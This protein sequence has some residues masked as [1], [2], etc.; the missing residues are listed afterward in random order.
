MLT[1]L[2]L[3]SGIMIA[4]VHN[5]HLKSIA[6]L[7]WRKYRHRYQKTVVEGYRAVSSAL[8]NKYPLDELL[9]CP[10]LLRGSRGT[11]LVR[12]VQRSGIRTTEISREALLRVSC[13]SRPQGLLA[14]APNIRK[15][16]DSLGGVKQGLY[17]VVESIEKPGNLGSIL[18]SADG[19]GAS[20]VI[21][22]DPRSDVYD[23]KCVSASMGSVFSVPHIEEST[24]RI[25]TWLRRSNIRILATSPHADTPHT[26]ANMKEG[27]AIAIG[28][29]QV[30][31]SDAWLRGADAHIR[32]PMQGQA[33]SLNVAA[34]ATVLLYEAIRQR[35]GL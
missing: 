19:V 12:Q 5:K 18:R 10:A 4:S 3:L 7:R 13:S 23:P 35:S 17:L 33:D 26:R 21:L 27:V 2:C 14:V 1:A 16:L 9:F 32:I 29:E 24:E 8:S 25:L 34:A 6:K 30:G 28:N 15:H 31:L 22:C 20:A 11:E